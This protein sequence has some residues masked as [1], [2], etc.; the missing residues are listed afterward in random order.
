MV[1]AEDEYVRVGGQALCRAGTAL[2]GRSWLRR[3]GDEAA[4]RVSTWQP[5]PLLHA[6][7]TTITC[8]PHHYYMQPTPLLRRRGDEA[9]R[10]VSTCGTMTVC[11]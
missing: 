4:R 7:H 11:N 2:L 6:A 3:R 8:S 5:T 9:A 1:P 10:R